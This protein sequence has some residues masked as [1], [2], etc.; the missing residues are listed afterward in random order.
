MAQTRNKK[1]Q[2]R[3]DLR[4]AQ[5]RQKRLRYLRIGGLL[6][7]AVAALAAF[8]F[9]RTSTAPQ[10]DAPEDVMAANIDGPADAPVNIVEFGDFGCPSCR[11]WHNA[12]I[13][14]QLKAQFGDQ[15]SFTFRHF[16][17]IT[18]LSPKAAEAGQCASEQGRFWEYH[19]FIYEQTPQNALANDDL[20]GY[21]QAIGLNSTE[22]DR[23]L[24]SDKYRSYVSRDQQAAIAAGAAGTPTFFINERLVSFSFESMAATIQHELES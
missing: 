18:R 6:I 13:K 19:D 17:V 10:I 7:L 14:D 3:K 16:P 5:Q 12:G 1:K 23:C 24:D 8:S 4:Q 21:A 22:F 15:I 9:Y 2:S 11:A 20:K